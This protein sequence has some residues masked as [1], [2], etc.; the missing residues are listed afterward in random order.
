MEIVTLIL[1]IVLLIAAIVIT[2]L[3]C[4]SNRKNRKEI[5]ALLETGREVCRRAEEKLQELERKRRN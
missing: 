5:D 2:I 1:A 4:R 3:R